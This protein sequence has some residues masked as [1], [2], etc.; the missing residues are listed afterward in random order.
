MEEGRAA[1]MPCPLCGQ[2]GRCGNP[3][4]RPD[5]ACWCYTAGFPKEIFSLIP[6]E[7]RGQACICP[8]CLAAFKRGELRTET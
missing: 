6:D 3:E 8:D 1:A 5:A 4:A 2:S 7:K